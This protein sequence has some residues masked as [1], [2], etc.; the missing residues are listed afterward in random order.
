[1]NKSGLVII[2]NN[3]SITGSMNFCF[4]WL[5]KRPLLVLCVWILRLLEGLATNKRQ[6][7]H[8]QARKK[9]KHDNYTMAIIDVSDKKKS[10]VRHLPREIYH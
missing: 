10:I 9:D 7:V 4:H 6:Q 5:C 1:M 2:M 3:N 8:C